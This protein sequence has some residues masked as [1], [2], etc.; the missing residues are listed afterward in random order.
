MLN[1]AVGHDGRCCS[2]C[3]EAMLADYPRWFPTIALLEQVTEP[4]YLEAIFQLESLTNPR[5]RGEV[6]NIR[7]VPPDERTSGPDVSINMA[8]F[9]PPNSEGS[10]F[11]GGT[12]AVFT[13]PERSFRPNSHFQE[14]ISSNCS[15]GLHN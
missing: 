7:P 9:N 14:T 4:E 13:V 6:G 11:S 8:A 3:V 15:F 10:R 2:H 5:L 12:Y 1:E